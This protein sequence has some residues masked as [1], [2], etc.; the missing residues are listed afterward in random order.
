MKLNS[1]TISV[2]TSNEHSME[3]FLNRYFRTKGYY[4]DWKPIDPKYKMVKE[5]YISSHYH[6]LS[7]T[8]E[9]GMDGVMSFLDNF[10]EMLEGDDYITVSFET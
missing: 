3:K 6:S 2:N 1:I 9:G 4:E 7:F 10:R 8:V 5:I